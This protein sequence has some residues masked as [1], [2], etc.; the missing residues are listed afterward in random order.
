MS[1]LRLMLRM[2]LRD[3]RAGELTVLGLALV[4]AVA[5]LTSVSFLTDRVAGALVLESHQLLGGDLL[6]SSD[7]PWAAATRERARRD[8]LALVDSVSF[9]SMVS[10]AGSQ[11]AEIKAVAT[12]YPLR[13][14]LRRSPALNAPDAETHQIPAPGTVWP[15]ERLTAAL[16]ARP[17][18]AITVGNLRLAVAGVLT[19]EP[20][21]GVNVFAFAPRL[22]MNLGDLAATGLIQPGSRVTYRLH[23]AGS[24][25]AVA[26][27]KNWQLRHMQR[28]EHLDDL[29]NARPEIRS[30]LD[31]AQRFLNLA[32]LLAVVLAA[33]A[34][35]FAADRYLRR[36][37][38]GCAVM[39]C[40]GASQA[41]VLTIH[42]GEFLIFGLLAASLGCA[43]GYLVQEGLQ[44][45]LSGIILVALP[46]PSWQPLSLGLLVGL[47]LVAGFALPPLLRLR[48]VSTLRV[49]RR[50]WAPGESLS[51]AA[52]AAGG[53]ALATLMLWIA[54]DL[55]LFAIVLGG[56]SAALILYALLARLLLAA[57]GRPGA[58][59]GAGWRLG[60]ANLRR[61]GRASVLQ[62]TAL[63]LGLT[64]L[65]LLTV[66]RQDLL[67][68]WRG[69]LPPDAANR[70]II[71][72]QPGQRAP[73]A[74][75]FV[76]QG[77]AKPELAPMVRAR[78]V[79]ING[80]AVDAASFEDPRAQHLVE[81][82][83]NL[84]W[85]AGLPPGNQ[86]VAGHWP[87]GGAASGTGRGQFSVEQGLAE[88]LHLALGDTLTYD[89][90]GVRLSGRITSLRRLAWDS[91]RVNFF[92]IAQPG[93][94]DGYP[95]SYVT[96]FHLAG[97]RS[98]FVSGLVREFPN[99]TVIDVGSLLRQLQAMLGQ[100]ADAL[101]VV[102]GF[103]LLA[104]LT[105]LY[106]ALQASQ[107]ERR[108]ELALL[109]ALGAR[110]RQL[111]SAVLAEFAL[112]GGIAGLLGG[113]GAAGLAW[114]LARLVFHLDYRPD[115]RLLL[116]GLA[117]GAIGAALAGWAGT[118]GVLKR[119]ALGALRGE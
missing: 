115:P 87:G 72:I 24:P 8:G 105:V 11:L 25:A 29:S 89:V 88:T 32:A 102:F 1:S 9:P 60:L 13:G 114:A 100:L 80:R 36:H 68:S 6:L 110:S 57:L 99:L 119:P 74:A 50:E 106:A 111:R 97:S 64:A 67:D 31:R 41:Q 117:A 23:L 43:L 47:T 48:A 65:L 5:S 104:G 77:L 4:V 71:N 10:A 45:L 33:V 75:H 26:S 83:F 63:G 82:E 44:G 15:D 91:M 76:A 16:G 35:G 27:F 113:V 109:R 86:I 73:L 19:Q 51:W 70:F 66:A 93:M 52:Y 37:L 84:S 96:S 34:V 30:M 95:T 92:V 58:R 98:G 59:V 103:A 21:R 54:G 56:F 118:A 112:L 17:G 79:R 46:A 81:R 107:D 3:A 53:A 101:Q 18:E 69:K 61:H 55:R 20:D 38:D 14:A 42:G 108:L 62:A 22:L 28:G 12:G 116:L 90:A 94:L 85:S 39:R 7:H 49:L 78:L 40:L 2:L